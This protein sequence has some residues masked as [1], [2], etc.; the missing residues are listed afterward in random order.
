MPKAIG[1]YSVCKSP[2]PSPWHRGLGF[3]RDLKARGVNEVYLV[4]SDAHLGIQ[5]AIGEVLPNASWQR[6]RTHFSKNLYGM[7][8]KTQWPTHDRRCSTRFSSSLMRHRCGLRPG[9]WWSS[10]SRSSRMWPITWRKP[11][12]SCWRSRTHR[13]RCGPRSGRITPPN[14]SIVKSAGVPM[15][16]G[17]S[18]TVTLSCAWSVLCS[19]NS[20]MI[21]SKQKRYMSLT[22]LKQTRAMMTANIIDAE[23]AASEVTRR[24]AA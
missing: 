19:R 13:R 8:P 14:G 6:C 9:M 24:D 1:N 11:W 10:V 20:M 7:V 15:L 23:A 17:S 5:H 4:T 3:F 21:G 12:M 2:Q 18:R 22:S 16:W